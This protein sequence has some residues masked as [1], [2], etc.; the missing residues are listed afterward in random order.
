MWELEQNDTGCQGTFFSGG[1]VLNPLKQSRVS[2]SSVLD[3]KH[4]KAWHTLWIES[5]ITWYTID[6]VLTLQ[7]AESVVFL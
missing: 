3:S 1:G 7:C 6:F 4:R 5:T 2:Y